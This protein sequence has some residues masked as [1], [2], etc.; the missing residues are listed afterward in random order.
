VEFT[1]A[2]GDLATFASLD[3]RAAY[4]G[5]ARVAAGAEWNSPMPQ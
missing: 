1:V 5:L 3:H 4:T 2:V